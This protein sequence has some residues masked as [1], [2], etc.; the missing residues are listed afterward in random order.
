MKE[1]LFS[2][3]SDKPLSIEPPFGG[4]E[5]KPQNSEN[6]NLTPEDEEF[7]AKTVMSSIGMYPADAPWHEPK[8]VWVN[9][10]KER[11][12]PI[13]E[14]NFLIHQ[15]FVESKGT[16]S[17]ISIATGI[18]ADITPQLNQIASSQFEQGFRG[19][20]SWQEVD[21]ETCSQLDG[22]ITKN[23]KDEGNINFFAQNPSI[24]KGLELI[25]NVLI[26][27]KN[28]DEIYEKHSEYMKSCI[29][30]NS[31]GQHILYI[32][33]ESDF[34][35]PVSSEDE[36]TQICEATVS[37][38]APMAKRERDAFD[39]LTDSTWALLK[40]RENAQQLDSRLNIIVGT[41]IMGAGFEALDSTV[42][43]YF[44]IKHNG[45][46]EHGFYLVINN[47]SKKIK[48]W[49]ISSELISPPVSSDPN[50][51]VKTM[52]LLYTIHEQAH[53]L[54][55]EHGKFGEVPADI[56]AVILALKIA[57]NQGLSKDEV[58][59]GI[60]TEHVSEIINGVSDTDWFEGHN[61]NSGN[62]LFDGYLISAVVIMNAV[63]ESGLVRVNREGRI[64]INLTEDNLAKLFFDLE[65][66]DVKFH[67]KDKKTLEKIKLAVANPEA[68][69]I[70]GLYRQKI[71]EM[72]FTK[73]T[74]LLQE[75][76]R[77]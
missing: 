59:K 57:K 63:A 39:R 69:E 35:K 1:L 27:S 70:I 58:V 48:Y 49:D 29:N 51:F 60:L 15:H 19:P 6:P 38:V 13:S 43:E 24:R 55:P 12:I 71:K 11:V 72:E 3:Q 37:V 42:G 64:D 36:V 21:P 77:Q 10:L 32:P 7:I 46:H 76:N 26:R 53:R 28:P 9:T 74:P 2:D 23:L 22:K 4:A 31:N 18:L 67:D 68:R 54:Y 50:N 20:K 56:P 17:D 45:G 61:S 47:L 34:T 65:T 73:G 66:V 8:D 25:Q 75:V 62:E 41:N 40:A 16:E 30:A 44:I 5:A 33:F 52:T 14:A